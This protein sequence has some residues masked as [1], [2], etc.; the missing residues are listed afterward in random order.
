MMDKILAKFRRPKRSDSEP[1]Q[2]EN[3]SAS[4][5]CCNSAIDSAKKPKTKDGA[6]GC[7]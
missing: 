6:H 4:D 5:D 2:A 3:K 7:C 1:G